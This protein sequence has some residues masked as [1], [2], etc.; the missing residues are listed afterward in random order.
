MGLPSKG[1]RQ[2]EVNGIR[3]RYGGSFEG[4]QLSVVIEA[5]SGGQ[6]LLA[7]FD[8]FVLRGQTHWDGFL[9]RRFV[10]IALVEGRRRGWRPGVPGK[11]HVL[12]EADI[13]GDHPAPGWTRGPGP[14]RR[15]LDA[16]LAAPGDDAPRRV[17]ADWLVE[18]CDPR[19]AFIHDQ[20]DGAPGGEVLQ[21][22]WRPWSAPAWR[23]ARRWD[24]ERG[25]IVGVD[26]H[27]RPPIEAWDELH[28]REPVTRITLWV[29]AEADPF[30]WLPKPT[31]RDLV[32]VG[33]VGGDRARGA[34]AVDRGGAAAPDH[35][36]RRLRRCRRGPPR[37][38]GGVGGARGARSA[39]S[40][41]GCGGDR[42]HR[43]VPAPGPDPGPGVAEVRPTP[44][45]R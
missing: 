44:R 36:P 45:S 41:H 7:R 16:V 17:L 40:P 14:G 28:A 8:P 15:L 37:P 12:T 24:F 6:R 18:R 27:Q 9:S 19:G 10:R 13:F 2:I 20:C 43:P 25:F 30:D 29:G 26:L 34:V 22:H 31:H 5:A 32:L 33:S 21:R 4:H 42:G 39:L 1:T 3:Y 11:P 23:V 35:H 38:G